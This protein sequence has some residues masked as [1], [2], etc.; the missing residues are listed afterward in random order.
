MREIMSEF[1]NLGGRWSCRVFASSSLLTFQS[2]DLIHSKNA[3]ACF[4]RKPTTQ[5]C[6]YQLKHHPHKSTLPLVFLQGLDFINP[7]APS[8]NMSMI[9]ATSEGI[10]SMPLMR[11]GVMTHA[12]AEVI[13]ITFQMKETTGGLSRV[14]SSNT[15]RKST[16][17]D[18]DLT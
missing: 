8:S 15:I 9:R 16:I 2:P 3:F 14:R 7:V 4:K 6:I 1:A 17:V 10:A 18:F 5:K 11:C 12:P 13:A